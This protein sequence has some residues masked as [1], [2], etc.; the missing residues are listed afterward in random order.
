GSAGWAWQAAA[1]TWLVRR[2]ARSASTRRSSP[3]STPPWTRGASTPTPQGCSTHRSRC[4][5]AR[6]RR[7]GYWRA[8]ADAAERPERRTS[9]TVV[10]V[11]FVLV[12]ARV[13]AG[14]RGHL[15]L[16]GGGA[17]GHLDLVR[18]DGQVEL[19]VD[20]AAGHI[21]HGERLRGGIDDERG[22]VGDVH[23]RAGLLPLH[24]LGP[25]PRHRD[26]VEHLTGLGIEDVQLAVG[27]VG[28]DLVVR[29]HDRRVLIAL[30]VAGALVEALDRDLVELPVPVDHGAVLT[31]ERDHVTGPGGPRGGLAVH[32]G[33]VGGLRGDVPVGVQGLH[34]AAGVLGALGGQQPAVRAQIGR[35]SCREA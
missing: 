8:W 31:A 9:A 22:A 13:L 2:A 28:L 30:L 1:G 18:H 15:V 32:A 14:S 21:D 27:G 7:P 24:G 4:R 6:M 26:L 33:A 10:P 23:H 19:A 12:A 3:S 20:L 29:E 5:R 11:A 16:P 35:A 17:G 25:F 34:D